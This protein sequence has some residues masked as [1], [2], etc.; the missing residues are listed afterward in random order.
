MKQIENDNKGR[1]R[2]QFN[3]KLTSVSANVLQNVNGTSYR[4][5]NIEFVDNNGVIQKTTAIMYEKN[6]EHGVT[7]G[8]EYV[9]TATLFEPT[10][11]YPKGSV[12]IQVSHLT[13]NADRPS[14]DMFL[15][16]TADSVAVA[17]V[18]EAGV[19]AD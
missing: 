6:Y 17:T 11:Q 8:T 10:E 15:G 5:C 19:V 2:I 14:L 16:A 1:T 13:A 18:K 12:L 3:A 9:S 7:E 4:V